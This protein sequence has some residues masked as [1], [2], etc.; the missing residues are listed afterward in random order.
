[1]DMLLAKR[2]KGKAA[3]ALKA[4]KGPAEGTKQREKTTRRL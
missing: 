2:E 1:M 4:E 3:L